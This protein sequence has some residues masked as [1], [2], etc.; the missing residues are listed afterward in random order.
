MQ[1]ECFVI[2]A[3]IVQLISRLLLPVLQDVVTHEITDTDLFPLN[4]EYDKLFNQILIHTHYNFSL[5]FIKSS[6]QCK[7]FY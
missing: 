3:T 4:I 5:K 2:Y 6:I 1:Q 7:H